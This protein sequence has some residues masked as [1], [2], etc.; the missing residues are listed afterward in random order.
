[1]TEAYTDLENTMIWY[2]TETAPISHI[3]FNFDLIMALN[4][5]STA[6]D[7]KEKIDLRLSAKPSWA[8]ANWVQGNHDRTRIASRYS[9]KQIDSFNILVMTLPGI[10][11]TYYGEEIGMEDN[12]DISWEDTQDPQACQTEDQENYKKFSRDPVRTPFQWDNTVSAGFSSTVDTWLPVHENYKTLNLKAQKEEE[13]SHF[14]IYQHLIKLRENES[15]RTGDFHSFTENNILAYTRGTDAKTY[16]VAINI[17]KESKSIDFTKVEG[18][19][20]F[21]NTQAKIVV[22]TNHESHAAG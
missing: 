6:A 4:E 13:R 21:N 9:T 20:K 19:K 16:G 3:P 15:F 12:Q 5:N 22:T 1:M 17:D 10:A 11:V 7:F 18:A 8:L 2:G 14:K